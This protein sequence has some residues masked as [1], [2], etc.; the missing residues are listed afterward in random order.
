[1]AR[2]CRYKPTRT[3]KRYFKPCDVAR[4]AANCLDDNPDLD[5]N[6]LLACVAKRLG[7]ESIVLHPE[8]NDRYAE[9]LAIEEELDGKSIEQIRKEKDAAEQLQKDLDYL[10]N[11]G[12]NS[13]EDTLRELFDLLAKL[14]R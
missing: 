10:D 13:L 3:Y 8:N 7:F 6:V 9:Y 14:F 1:M 11:A 4:I 12:I 2:V 5:V